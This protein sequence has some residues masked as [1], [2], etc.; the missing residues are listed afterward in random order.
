MASKPEFV[1]TAESFDQ[2][3]PLAVQI[4]QATCGKKNASGSCVYLYDYIERGRGEEVNGITVLSKF[5]S[6]FWENEF[7][8][9]GILLGTKDFLALKCAIFFREKEF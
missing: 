5:I 1:Y 7:F 9:G 8:S 4:T 6:V 3:V 2:L